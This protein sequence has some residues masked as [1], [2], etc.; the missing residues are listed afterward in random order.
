MKVTFYR[1]ALNSEGGLYK[2]PCGSIDYPGISDE[3]WVVSDA[4]K[5]FQTN[6]NVENWKEIAEFYEIS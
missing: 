2:S 6:H 1:S 3:A 4:I 5:Q